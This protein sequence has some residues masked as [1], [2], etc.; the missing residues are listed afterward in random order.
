MPPQPDHRALNVGLV[1]GAS[2]KMIVKNYLY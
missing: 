2:K 1:V